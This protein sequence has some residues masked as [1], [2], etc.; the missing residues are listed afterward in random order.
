[1]LP[2]LVFLR[3]VLEKVACRT[4]FFDG[5]I[6]VKRVV[7]RGELMVVFR[8]EKHATFLTIFSVFS[9]ETTNPPLLGGFFDW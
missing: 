2:L 3:G 8:D 9:T 7:K 1:L 4:W 6:V 5:E